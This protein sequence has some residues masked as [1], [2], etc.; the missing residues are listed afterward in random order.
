M[1]WGDWNNKVLRGV[2]R[3]P[4][5]IWSLVSLSCF[6]VGFE[7]KGFSLLFDNCYFAW[8]E[9][10]FTEGSPFLGWFFCCPSPCS[11]S[12]FSQLKW[13]FHIIKKIIW[14]S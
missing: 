2:K 4:Y 7:F 14:T 12:F 3:D 11:F 1:V 8:L 5:E 13:L 10:H 6:S 9:S